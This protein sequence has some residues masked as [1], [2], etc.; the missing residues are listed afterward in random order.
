MTYHFLAL[1][2]CGIINGLKK[3]FIDKRGI[4][5]FHF[6]QYFKYLL[7]KFPLPSPLK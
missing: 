3:G 4:N 5:E 2:N 7:E 1:A 6:L